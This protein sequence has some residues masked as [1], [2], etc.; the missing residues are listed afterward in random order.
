MSQ[1]RYFLALC[2]ERSFT[3]AAR[4]CRVSQPSLSNGIKALERELG[5][6]LFERVSMTLTPL[7]KRV[8]PHLE[9]AI[10]SVARAQRTA[11]SLRRRA[12]R[13][14][15]AQAEVSAPSGLMLS[16]SSAFELSGKL[17]DAPHVPASIGSG[18]AA[19][20]SVT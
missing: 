12:E 14:L 18:S 4:Q 1:I 6:K 17:F 2:T 16:G 13:Q 3:R 15:Q 7:G 20:N 10:A 19:R 9:N 5:G 11:T 8:R